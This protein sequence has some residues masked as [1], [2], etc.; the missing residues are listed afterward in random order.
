MSG[1][2]YQ[3]RDRV[4]RITLDEP[5]TRNAMTATMQEGLVAAFRQAE[6]SSD[7]SVILLTGSGDT[8]CA[9]GDLRLMKEF[10]EKPATE[11]YTAARRS[12]DLFKTMLALETPIVAAVN[13]PA[14]GG[15]FGVVCSSA[16]VVASEK[17]KFGCTELKIGLFPL[18]ILPAIR[19]ALGDRKALELSLLAE[20]LDA[21]AALRSE[22]HTSELQ[23]LLRISY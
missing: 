2:K 7:V 14:L 6:A 3:V 18:V 15:G 10:R 21:P 17:A 20:L 1:V 13:G 9:G 12:A 23:S 11:I 19:R 5:E 8:F 4:A 16:L 22:E